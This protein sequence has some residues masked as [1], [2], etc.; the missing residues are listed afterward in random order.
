MN[1]KINLN[2][3][4]YLIAIFVI[5]IDLITKKITDGVVFQEGIKG[6]FAIESFH[7]TGAS[8]SMFAGSKA[9]Q[10]VFIILG[11]IVSVLIVL[12][13]LLAKKSNLNAWFFVGASLMVGGII[14]NVVDRIFLGYV[15]DFI[16]LQF[17]NFAV[18]NIADSA[19][20]IGVICLIVWL[21]FFS[22]KEKSNLKNKKGK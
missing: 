11:I 3:L 9:A 10:I 5:I 1:K 20:T 17:M 8:F 14:G 7:N 6:V 4:W 13:S 21:L 22:Y 12:Y 16:S 19:L 18:F 2:F 15:R